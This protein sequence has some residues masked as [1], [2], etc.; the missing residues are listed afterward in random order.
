MLETV[1]LLAFLVIFWP[2]TL[3]IVVPY[4]AFGWMGPAAVITIGLVSRV[5]CFFRDAEREWQASLEQPAAASDE[6]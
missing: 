3:T 6:G 2:F 5:V 1:G 4:L